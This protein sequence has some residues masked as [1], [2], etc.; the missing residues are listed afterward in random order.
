MI[1]TVLLFT[2]CLGI[3][4]AS[5]TVEADAGD[6]YESDFATGTIF[7]FTRDANDEVV[8]LTYATNLPDVRG[9]TFDHAGNLFVG[10][11]ETI[12]KITP[13]GSTTVFASDLHGPNFLTTDQT[14]NLYASDRDGNVLR[15]TPAGERSVFVSGLSKPS[16]LAFDFAGNLFVADTSSNAIYRFTPSGE[17]ST[18]AAGL[19]I[20]QGLTVAPVRNV[21]CRKRWNGD[22]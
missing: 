15:F 21:V 16:G 4:L 10:Q 12:I 19:S 1:K 7:R 11:S 17:R 8:K 6:V 9:L 2:T 13:G 5:P 18:F 20:P 14:G 3:F 22:G